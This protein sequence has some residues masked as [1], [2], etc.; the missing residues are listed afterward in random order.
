MV[1]VDTPSEAW[2]APKRRLSDE[3][4]AAGVW[5]GSTEGGTVPVENEENLQGPV[6]A[7]NRLERLMRCEERGANTGRS[8]GGDSDAK[9]P[10]CSPDQ[11]LVADGDAVSGPGRRSTCRPASLGG[12]S[13]WRGIRHPRRDSDRCPPNSC[14]RCSGPGRGFSATS[15]RLLRPAA[16]G[17]R[18]A[19]GHRLSAAPARGLQ[20]STCRGPSR[21]GAIRPREKVGLEAPSSEARPSEAGMEVALTGPGPWMCLAHQDSD[22][23]QTG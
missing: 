6:Y 5:R 23:C 14:S 11:Q 17:V 22:P 15:C 8:W 2:G 4:S 13:H 21:L 1:D 12:S 16:S 20:A 18:G 7:G 10:G 3:S 9:D 19:T